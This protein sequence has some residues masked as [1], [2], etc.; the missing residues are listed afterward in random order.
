MIRTLVEMVRCMLSYA[1]LLPGYWGEAIL[2]ACVIRNHCPSSTL[3][4]G[5]PSHLWTGRSPQN[6]E[7][8]TFG[9]PV[10]AKIPEEKRRKLDPKSE[11]CIYLGPAHNMK[12]HR[13]DSLTT[14]K[15]VNTRSCTFFPMETTKPPRDNLTVRF[16]PVLSYAP[17][18][19]DSFDTSAQD[20][21]V[22]D[23][24]SPDFPGYG[25]GDISAA[26]PQMLPSP[27][28][29]L[30]SDVSGDAAEAPSIEHHMPEEEQSD[31]A[32]SHELEEIDDDIYEDAPMEF[33]EDSDS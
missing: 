30:V 4:S 24:F 20:E 21:S 9:A 7:F 1:L 8:Q 18:S 13:V 15:I 22:V 6:S 12:A 29:L 27:T 28:D 11:T 5:T 14:R 32:P 19:S 2:Y 31:I 17:S 25:F 23:E 16:N 33:E 3:K 10:F 26:S